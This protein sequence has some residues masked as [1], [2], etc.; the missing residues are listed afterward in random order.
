MATNSV[1]ASEEGNQ[2]EPVPN[3][4]HL[5]SKRR[6][7]GSGL[8]VGVIVAVVLLGALIYFLPHMAKNAP[9]AT[10]ARLVVKRVPGQ[11]QFHGIQVIAGPTDN[12][13][14]LVGHITNTGPDAVT[15]VLADVKL[16]GPYEKVLLDVKR[17]M[18]GMA[19]DDNRLVSDPFAKDPLKPDDTRPF[20]LSI[21][22]AP[23]WW[24]H[25]LPEVQ[26]V[27]VTGQGS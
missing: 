20:R 5:K 15:G 14:Y 21:T 9:T 2:P 13:F 17:P 8:I 3:I 19:G 10:N 16:R 11:L 26:I 27:Q 6:R 24:N 12:S 1:S 23:A 7:G 18:E 22:R 25:N 4:D